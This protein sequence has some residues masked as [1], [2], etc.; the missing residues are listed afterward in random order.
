MYSLAHL[1]VFLLWCVLNNRYHQ[2]LVVLQVPP[3]LPT[4]DPLYHLQVSHSEL[5]A[6]VE[7]GGHHCRLGV[8]VDHSPGI[9]DEG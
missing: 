3:T 5:C 9:W 6:R 1:Q 8:G 2:L 7:E 4:S